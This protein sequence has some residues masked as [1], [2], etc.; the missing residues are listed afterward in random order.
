VEGGGPI[1]LRCVHRRAAAKKLLDLGPI[2]V[3]GGVSD[4]GG[5]RSEPEAAQPGSQN[6]ERDVGE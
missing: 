1:H 2:A 5:L 6:A 4:R 3:F